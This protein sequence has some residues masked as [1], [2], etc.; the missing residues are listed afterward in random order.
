M[1]RDGIINSKGEVTRLVG[2]AAEPEPWAKRPFPLY[3]DSDGANGNGSQP[4][5]SP[6]N[7][8]N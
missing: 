6:T 3:P 1:V 7:G 8:A 5:G 2:G 4:N